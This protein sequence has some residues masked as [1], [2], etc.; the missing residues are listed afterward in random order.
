MP[1]VHNGAFFI[2]KERT[3]VICKKNNGT[4]R[5]CVKQTKPDLE[6]QMRFPSDVESMFYVLKDVKAGSGCGALS[7]RHTLSAGI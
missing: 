6:R 7:D 1:Y 3:D 5:H 4:G 2:W